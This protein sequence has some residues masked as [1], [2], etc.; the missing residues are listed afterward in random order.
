MVEDMSTTPATATTDDGPR[1]R[2]IP[3]RAGPYEV[4]GPPE[5]VDPDGRPIQPPIE[6]IYLCRCGRSDNKPFC[7]GSHAR[8]GWTE[9]T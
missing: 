6:Q 7:D 9:E 5:L 3:L 2:L 1:A 4:T 8:T